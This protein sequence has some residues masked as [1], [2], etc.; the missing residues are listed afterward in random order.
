M[1]LFVVLGWGNFG[2]LE[3][4]WRNGLDDLAES[5]H[6]NFKKFLLRSNI[7]QENFPWKYKSRSGIPNLLKIVWP[8][9]NSPFLH[10]TSY[11]MYSSPSVNAQEFCLKAFFLRIFEPIFEITGTIWDLRTISSLPSITIPA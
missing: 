10:I 11:S 8:H 5:T 6:T 4:P 9:D 7:Q 1:E 2:C 3:K